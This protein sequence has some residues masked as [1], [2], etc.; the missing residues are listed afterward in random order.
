MVPTA[1]PWSMAAGRQEQTEQGDDDRR[2]GEQHGPA[3]VDQRHDHGLPRV[4]TFEQLPA[5]TG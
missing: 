3:E 4:P 5:G 1:S 2:P